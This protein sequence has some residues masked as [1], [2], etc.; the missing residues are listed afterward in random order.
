MSAFGD[1]YSFVIISEYFDTLLC[2]PPSIRPCRSSIPFALRFFIV[3]HVCALQEYGVTSEGVFVF[4]DEA[5]RDAGIDPKK[6]EKFTLKLTGVSTGSTLFQNFG[7]ILSYGLLLHHD[8]HSLASPISAHLSSLLHHDLHSLVSSVG[9]H[10]PS[11]TSSY[12]QSCIV[13]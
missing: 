12:R 1:V 9:A 11:R 10:F 8:L 6:G 4:L 5:L 7:R 2:F 13:R 3:C